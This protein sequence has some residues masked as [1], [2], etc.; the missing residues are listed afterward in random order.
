MRFS[1]Y[2]HR[3]FGSAQT[4]ESQVAIKTG[5][6]EVLSEQVSQSYVDL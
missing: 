2:H 1:F 4:L 3:S 6:L 5:I